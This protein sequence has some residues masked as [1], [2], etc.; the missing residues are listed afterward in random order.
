LTLEEGQSIAPPYNLIDNPNTIL[1]FTDLVFVDP[2]GTGFSRMAEEENLALVH[3]VNSDIRSLG[4]FICDYI[5]ATGCWTSP[6][7]LAGS[8]YGTHRACGLAQYLA[9]NGLYL[10]GLILMGCALD[11]QT[12]VFMPDNELPFALFLPSFAATA[13]YHGRLNPNT[14]LEQTIENARR[15][16]LDTF[17]PALLVHGFL[18]PALYQDLSYWTG[19]PVSTIQEYDGLINDAVFLSEFPELP[20]Q[21]LGRIDSRVIGPAFSPYSYTDPSNTP[22]LGILTAAIHT[23]L[24]EELEYK[25]IYPRYVS[26]NEDAL[27]NWGWPSDC[28]TNMMQSLRIA[29]LL[30]PELRIFNASG[31]FDLATPFAAVEHSFKRLRLPLAKNIK[32]CYY[33]GG[34]GFFMDP[35]VMSKFKKDLI[36]FF[37]GEP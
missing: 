29:L 12:L 7:Y 6:K 14:S 22:Y 10:N 3:G 25:N 30:N 21:H 15:F 18:P 34:H 24:F 16:A 5:T 9:C 27:I 17:A 2:I 23:Y 19:L 4:D 37:Q 36:S 33:E 28:Y 26:F 20:Q 32:F 1:D 35:E 11:Y 31:Y 8:S 13:W